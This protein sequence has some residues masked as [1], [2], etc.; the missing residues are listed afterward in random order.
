MMSVGFSIFYRVKLNKKKASSKIF[1]DELE[2]FW[3]VRS[4]HRRL[5]SPNHPVEDPGIPG[6][7]FL[8]GSLTSDCSP[9]GVG[10]FTPSTV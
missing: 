7:L 5:P 10:D 8:R 1:D 6:K 9:V 3:N 4:D 2:V